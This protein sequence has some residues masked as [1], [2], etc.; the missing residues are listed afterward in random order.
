GDEFNSKVWPELKE[1]VD[2]LME[3]GIYPSMQVRLDWSIHQMDYF[4]KNCYKFHLD[5]CCEDD[6]GDF[7][8]DDEG[9]VVDMKPEVDVNVADSMEINAAPINDVSN[10]V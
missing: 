10:G 6:E 9:I 3:A 8:S 4:Y 2:I 7:E 5:P 1:E